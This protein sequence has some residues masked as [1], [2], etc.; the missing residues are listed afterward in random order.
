MVF[1]MHKILGFIMDKILV[2]Y[3][4]NIGFIIDKICGL[5]GLKYG[6]LIWTKY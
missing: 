2:Y 4:E 5:L 3:E 1:V 6:S